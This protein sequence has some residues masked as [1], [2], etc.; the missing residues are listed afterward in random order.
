MRLPFSLPSFIFSLHL[1]SVLDIALLFRRSS[2][3]IF[4]GGFIF[5]VVLGVG[6]FYFLGYRATQDTYRPGTKLDEINGSNLEKALERLEAQK[7]KATGD[8]LDVFR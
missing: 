6:A 2:R 4:W 8:P 5:F 3:A 1:P 7:T